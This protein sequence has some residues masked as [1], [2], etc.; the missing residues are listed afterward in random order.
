MNSAKINELL[1][2]KLGEEAVIENADMKFYTSFRAGGQAK[3]LIKPKSLEE[4]RYTLYM[5]GRTAA[6]DGCSGCGGAACSSCNVSD[7]GGCGA[8]TPKTCGEE[9]SCGKAVEYIVLGNGS[10]VLVR[11]GG[12]D[13]AI[14]R[15]GEGFD[16]I[17]VEGC[18]IVAGAGALLSKVAKVAAEASLTGFEFA[19]GIP[20]S[21]GGAVFMN[22][23]AYGGEM[24]NILK[25]VKLISKDGTVEKIVPVSELN[26]GYRHSD[27]ME[28]GDVVVEARF[29]LEK[30]DKDEIREQMKELAKKRNEKQP[31]NLPS[32]GSFFKRPEGHFAGALVEGSGLKGLS[33]GGAQVSPL[34]AGFIVNNGGATSEDIERLMR[35]VQNTV[36]RDSGVWLEP[37]VRIIGK[38][39]Y[40]Q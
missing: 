40:E 9:S 11:D 16:D 36:K 10:N 6:G 8:D 20:G 18:E 31:V 1:I 39:N 17:S 14:V 30:G 3:L 15:I 21:V 22:A 12:F 7:C 5:L 2:S 29:V 27:L 38:K 25:E 23:G 35:L 32:A 4:L 37:E 33:V 19:S 26:L 34:H 28:S 24:A 13:G